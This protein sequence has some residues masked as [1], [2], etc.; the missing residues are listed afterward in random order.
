MTARELVQ[1]LRDRWA[2]RPRIT[3]TPS[4]MPTW[5]LALTVGLGLIYTSY[6]GWILTRVVPL[7]YEASAAGA[8]FDRTAAILTLELLGVGAMTVVC[9]EITLVCRTELRQRLFE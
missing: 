3:M 9:A 6:L 7:Y 5:R 1:D 8:P 2:R 4:R